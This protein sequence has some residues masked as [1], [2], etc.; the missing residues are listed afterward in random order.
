MTTTI[1]NRIKHA[2]ALLL[3]IA[4]CM[5]LCVTGVYADS[6]VPTYAIKKIDVPA[7]DGVYYAQIDLW[8]ASQN[9]ASMGNASLRGSSSFKNNQPNDTYS[10]AILVVKDN[11]ATALLEFM[12]MGFLG[13]YGFLMELESVDVKHLQQWGGVYDK[14]AAYTPA[15]SLAKHKTTTGDTVYDSYNNPDSPDVFDGSQTRPAGF[16]YDE[17]RTVNI[18]GVPYSHLLALD[19]TPISIADKNGTYTDPDTAADYNE[20]NAAYVH[21]FVP[22][23]FSIG[24]SFGDQYAKLKV[25]WTSLEKIQDPDSN[26]TYKLWEAKQTPQGDASD[27]T[28][29]ALQAAI[30]EVTEKMENIWPSQQLSMNGTQPKLEQKEFTAEEQAAMVKTLNDAM[31]GLA[32]APDKTALAAK[33]SEAKALSQADYSAADYSNLQS[34][35]RA[36]ETVN[37]SDD[38]TQAQIDAA[39]EKLQSVIDGLTKVDDAAKWTNLY[40]MASALDESDYT[41]ESWAEFTKVWVDGKLKNYPDSSKL[42]MVSVLKVSYYNTRLENAM[43][44]LVE[45]PTLDTDPN[46]LS[47]GKYTLKA[48]M[49]KTADPTV[50]SMSN[51]AINHNVWL[52]VKDGKY[53]L[54][55]QFI[56][57][58]IYNQFGYLKD[59]KYFDLGYTIGEYGALQGTLL[60]AT[61]LSTQKDSTGKDVIDRYN[62]AENLYPEMVRFELVEKA[63]KQYT[64]LQVFVPIMENISAGLGTQSVYMELDWSKLRADDGSVKKIDPPVQSPEL[65]VTDEATGVKIHADKGVF[66]EGTKLVV[67]PVTS[68]AI[69]DQGKESFAKKKLGDTFVVYDVS[70]TNAQGEAVAPNGFVTYSLPIPQGYNPDG[71]VLM[72]IN[73]PEDNIGPSTQISGFTVEN[74]YLSIRYNARTAKPIH[75]ALVDNKPYAAA[76]YTAV[77]EALA[78]I[79]AD[80]SAYTEESVQ[81]VEAAK[82]AVVRGKNETE[83]AAVDAMAKAINDAVAALK[84][85]DST[86]PGGSNIPG[87]PNNGGEPKTGDSGLVWFLLAGMAAAGMTAAVVCSKK[88]KTF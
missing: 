25:D 37:G 60:P 33:I 82:G 48:Y 68:G 71:L 72:K 63:A 40:H 64:A 85:K 65:D 32:S 84:L 23:M 8:N 50:H 42:P 12:P 5:S 56:G 38:A 44:A 17:D 20:D 75:F 22:V 19:A 66:D 47:D 53:Y 52:E 87:A 4:M 28:Y 13:K 54:T 81:A 24:P 15:V 18:S 29:A 46:R 27:A 14:T 26:L 34:A 2:V 88:R 51:N 21:V 1:R 39:A 36:A 83:Q 11:K 80:L 55:V 70:F 49:Y 62:D 31:D 86:T 35:I 10:K 9:N 76:D 78:K 30:A 59:L 57:M 74:G 77:D 58:N 73:D 16:G 43:N 6:G 7:E 79:P 41:A 69:Y 3:A 45:K 67:T 61:V